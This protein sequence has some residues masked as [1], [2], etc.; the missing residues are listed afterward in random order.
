MCGMHDSNRNTPTE[1]IEARLVY[2]LSFVSGL[3]YWL[4]RVARP[5]KLFVEMRDVYHL[6]R[7]Q[8]CPRP[9]ERVVPTHEQA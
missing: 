6:V 9:S 2:R 8:I 7:R 5:E 1:S 4:M 3:P